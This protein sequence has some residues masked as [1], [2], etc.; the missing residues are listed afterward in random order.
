[1]P[2]RHYAVPPPGPPQHPASAY[3]PPVPPEHWPPHAP[4]PPPHQYVGFPRPTGAPV[5]PRSA[6]LSPGEAEKFNAR[7]SALHEVGNDFGRPFASALMFAALD[8]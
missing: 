2:P 8:L 5:D 1:M 6:A 3:P 4:P 7:Q